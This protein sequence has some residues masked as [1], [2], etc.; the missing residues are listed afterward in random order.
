MDGLSWPYKKARHVAYHQFCPGEPIRSETAWICP[1][2]IEGL[3]KKLQ[4][5]AMS[6]VFPGLS[7]LGD[8]TALWND[9][10]CVQQLEI[11]A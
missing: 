8:I 3:V 7:G 4:M 11:R 6:K 10:G 1:V 2:G 9:A 5:P